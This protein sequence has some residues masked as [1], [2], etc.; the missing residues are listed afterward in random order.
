MILVLLPGRQPGCR[1]DRYVALSAVHTF[2]VIGGIWDELEPI[3]DLADA[4]CRLGSA[5]ARNCLDTSVIQY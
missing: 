2:D 3:R 4:R 5:Y 1:A